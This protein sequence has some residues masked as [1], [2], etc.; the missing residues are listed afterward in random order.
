MDSCKVA[1]PLT[2]AVHEG[3]D[4]AKSNLRVLL[5]SCSLRQVPARLRLVRVSVHAV[6]SSTRAQRGHDKEFEHS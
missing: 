2:E 4:V 5:S 6:Y 1:L 3:L